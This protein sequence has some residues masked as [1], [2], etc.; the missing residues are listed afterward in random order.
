MLHA[1]DHLSFF[2]YSLCFQPTLFQTLRISSYHR[3]FASAL[4]AL[5]QSG[6]YPPDRIHLGSSIGHISVIPSSCLPCCAP[7]VW[8][9]LILLGLVVIHNCYHHSNVTFNMDGDV[10]VLLTL[11]P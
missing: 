1:I 4:P 5:V 2:D 6:L 8:S 9:D 11:A 3:T 7:Q 10:I